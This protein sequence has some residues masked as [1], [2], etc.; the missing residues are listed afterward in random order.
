MSCEA[1]DSA[2]LSAFF[3]KAFVNAVAV[4][5]EVAISNTKGSVPA[6]EV[7]TRMV[8]PG[9]GKIYPIRTIEFNRCHRYADRIML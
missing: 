8:S 3:E 2:A 1:T 5:A 7:E 6:N 9:R 4:D